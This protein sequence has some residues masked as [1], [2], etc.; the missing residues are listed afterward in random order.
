MTRQEEGTSMVKRIKGLFRRVKTA[1][2]A[3][4]MVSILPTM[5]ITGNEEASAEKSGPA[6]TPEPQASLKSPEE[7]IKALEGELAG[8]SSRIIELE[9]L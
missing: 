5:R 6:E 8:K 4:L 7:R 2:M 3:L 9:R 1:M